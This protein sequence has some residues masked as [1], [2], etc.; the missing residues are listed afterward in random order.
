MYVKAQHTPQNDP[1]T[2]SGTWTLR[3]LDVSCLDRLR[4]LYYLRGLDLLMGLDIL[5]ARISFLWLLLQ[6]TNW[7]G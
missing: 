3:G 5:G 1:L 4:D 2:V 7:V 6:R